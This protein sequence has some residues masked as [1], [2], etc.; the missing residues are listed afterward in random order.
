M[1]D[2][3][4]QAPGSKGYGPRDYEVVRR[5]APGAMLLWVVPVE[6]D[7]EADAEAIY[8][9]LE[10]TNMQG[11]SFFP[12]ANMAKRRWINAYKAALAGKSKPDV[13]AWHTVFMQAIHN[14]ADKNTAYDAVL[15][16]ALGVGEE[17]P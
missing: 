7:Y 6:P 4:Q 15:D 12:W 10:A 13:R 5:M 2:L 14:G 9:Y 11:A 16:A 1:T 8:A 17:T 3:Y